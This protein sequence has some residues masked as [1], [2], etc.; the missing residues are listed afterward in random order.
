[1]PTLRVSTTVDADG[2]AGLRQERRDLVIERADGEDRWALVEGPFTDYERS[3]LVRPVD[4]SYEVTE[5]TEYRLATP[6]WSVLIR[7]LM[8]RALRSTDRTPRR[9]WW[10][11][12]EVVKRRTAVLVSTLGFISVMTGYLGVVIGQTITFAAEDFGADDSAEANTLAAVRV[13]VVLSLLLVP[14]ADRIGRRPLILGLAAGAVLFTMA[15][16]FASSL[17]TLGA[18][19]TVAR[20]LT[21][22]LITLLV[23][24]ATEEVPAGV[25]AFTISLITLCFALGAGMVIWVLP[26]DDLIDGGW[27]IV[28]LVPGLFLPVLWWV[29]KHLPETRRFRAA[30]T[31]EAPAV[32]DWRRFAMLGGGA[33]L[34]TFFLSPAS[35]LRNEFLRDDLGY[36]A[37]IVSVF[38]LVISAPAGTAIL[39]A[40]IAAD[41][42]G[43]RWVGA[44]GLS[45]GVIMLATSYQLTGAGLWLAASAGVVL[46]GAAFPAT[47]GYQ[48]E[49]FPT[50]ARAKVG[51]LLD[52]VGVA[53]SASG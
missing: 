7:P 24:A 20:G 10:W 8:S 12:A 21:T 44:V 52:V 19:Q 2:L 6:V 27:R 40:G 14:R 4:G 17:Q 16:A 49:L 45:A 47:R 38:Q 37:S 1:M 50:R 29:A 11:P 53:G 48:T 23:L 34:S 41:R 22:G 51:G 31:T 18:A 9:R 43:R 26:V 46:T 25:R 5:T 36:S 30:T 15:G 28:Y 39:L 3:L 13:G 42:I 32:I 35:Q 33:F